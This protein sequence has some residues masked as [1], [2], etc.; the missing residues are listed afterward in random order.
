MKRALFVLFAV[1]AL[2][3]CNDRPTPSGFEVGGHPYQWNMI[4]F[5]GQGRLVLSRMEGPNR[6]R[7]VLEVICTD[8]G[9]GGLTLNFGDL[10]DGSLSLTAGG[11]VFALDA[12]RKESHGRISLGGQGYIPDG[13]YEALGA[14]EQVVITHGRDHWAFDGP[15]KN[16]TRHFARYC[17]RKS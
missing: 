17:R 6:G 5:P 12:K 10:T 4:G 2:T 14:A 9:Y 11:K 3:A 1:L 7:A 15:G 13:W 16:L 8:P